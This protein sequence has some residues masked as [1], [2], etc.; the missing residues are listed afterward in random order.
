M[1]EKGSILSAVVADVVTLL[2]ADATL[3]AR[4]VNDNGDVQVYNNVPVGTVPPYLWVLSES[5]YDLP[6]KIGAGNYGRGC[7]V[8]VCPVSRHRGTKEIDELGSAAMEALERQPL[9][10]PGYREAGIVWDETHGPIVMEAEGGMQFMRE[11]V[12]RASAR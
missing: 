8:K 1:S 3:S 5:E 10:I 9:T 11:L 4:L 2:R 7:T 12:F 6:K